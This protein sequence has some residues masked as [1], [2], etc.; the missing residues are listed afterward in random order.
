MVFIF[1]F[2]TYF[3]LYK[4]LKRQLRSLLAKEIKACFPPKQNFQNSAWLAFRCFLP[5]SFLKKY[6]VRFL[7]FVITLNF[8]IDSYLYD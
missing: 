6:T 7:L 8:P 3:T 5:K 1:L 4:R 2:L